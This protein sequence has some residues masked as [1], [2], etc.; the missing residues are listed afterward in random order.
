[1][2]EGKYAFDEL[3]KVELFIK[4]QIVEKRVERDSI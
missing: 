4:Q 3:S 2:S 1:V